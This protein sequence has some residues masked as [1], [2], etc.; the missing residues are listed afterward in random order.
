MQKSTLV[1]FLVQLIVLSTGAVAS[2]YPISGKPFCGNS[3]SIPTEYK[4]CG[5][6][7]L[8]DYVDTSNI[9]QD[10]SNAWASAALDQYAKDLEIQC[11]GK[12]E[13]LDS[14]YV[15]RS[16]MDSR[17]YSML[18]S[19]KLSCENSIDAALLWFEFDVMTKPVSLT[20][21]MNLCM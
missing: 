20:N 9:P 6:G 1:T 14:F 16:G 8:Y 13:I 3:T 19:A 2:R 12:A 7:V 4:G 21:I 5:Y 15:C 10:I 17:V 11:E 18:I